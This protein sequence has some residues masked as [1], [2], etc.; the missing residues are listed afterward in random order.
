MNVK[1]V[2]AIGIV[3]L[4]GLLLSGVVYAH[5]SGDYGMG[6][7][8]GANVDNVRKFQKETLSLRDELMTKQIE[9]QNE[10]NKSI[11]DTRRIAT[12]K[13]EII[14]IE[15]KIQDAADKYNVAAGGHRSG[16]MMGRGMTMGCGMMGSGMGM[17]SCPNCGW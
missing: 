8:T 10:Y 12:V 14:D 1:K 5:W 15:S 11:P 6:Y 3:V 4:T 13:K 9:L 2:M 17:Y 16:M 7:G